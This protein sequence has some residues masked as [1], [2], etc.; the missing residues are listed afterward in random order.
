V[1]I[2]GEK[3][4][5]AQP[6]AKQDRTMESNQTVL[7][8][9]KRIW[10]G[11]VISGVAVLFLVFDSVIKLMQVPA[12]VQGASELG[13]PASLMPVIGSILLFCVVVY[14][15]PRTAPLGAILLTGYFGGAVASQL[16]IGKPLLG[17]TL[18]PIYVAVLIWGGLYL[19]DNRVRVLFAP[20][21]Q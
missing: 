12:V 21:A 18:F 7:G 1:S 13:Y 9:K 2:S 3:K 6:F 8:S 5:I 11:R 17:Y 19:R 15:I 14:V 10:A 4:T 16:R 20:R